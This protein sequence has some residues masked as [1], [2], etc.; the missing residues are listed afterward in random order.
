VPSP[1]TVTR[2]ITGL[3]PNTTHYARAFASNAQGDDWATTTISFTTPPALPSVA[4]NQPAGIDA[5]S[6]DLGATVTDSGGDPPTLTIYYGT[7]DGGTSPAAWQFS[8]SL[9]IQS[10]AANTSIT[11]LAHST[12][13]FYRASASNSAGT[14]WAPSS[15]NFS[16]ATLTLPSVE[17]LAATSI[18]GIST[19]L[20]GR[21][22]STGGDAPTVTFYYGTTDGG[23]D[24]DTWDD[25]VQL[26]TGSG[27]FSRTIGSLSPLTSYFFRAFAENAAG[28][29]WASPSLQFTTTEFVPA[30]IVINEIHYDEDIKSVQG[31]FIELYNNSDDAV[32]LSAWYFSSG[33]D[34]TFPDP[35][36]IP[37]RSYLV[38]AQNPATVQTQFGYSDALG[39]WR[40]KL[41]NDGETI[42]LRD[43]SG[44][45]VDK[46]DYSLGFPW[47]TVGTA[48]SPSI[49]LVNPSLEN[50]IGGHWRAAGNIPASSS[51][52]GVTPAVYIPR[53]SSAWKYT[54]G[55]SI[56]PV[57]G[58]GKNWNQ[59]G[60]DDSSWTTARTP[61]GYSD[62]DD[63]TTIAMEDNFIT[64]FARH[65]FDIAPGQVPSSLDLELLYDDA[66]AVWV[67]GTKVQVT[68]NALAGNIPTPP[69]NNLVA[70]HE[71]NQ[72]EP[73]GYEFFPLAG[74]SG[75]LVEG[76]NSI[77]IQHVN[78]TLS[79]SD[80]SMEASLATGGA[81]PGGYSPRDPS[82]GAA[83]SVL[84]S[85]VAPALRKVE[86]SP[87]QPTS[88][89]P[90]SIT[91][92]A[93]DNDG[94]ASV[95]LDYQ[96]VDPG[97]YINI[98][99]PRYPTNW[100]TLTMADDGTGGDALTGD[101]VFTATLPAS[102]QNHRRLIR[103]RI[104]ATDSLGN[105]VTAPHLD[106]LQPKFAYFVYAAI[107][108]WTASSSSPTYDFTQLE[109]V[110]VYQLIT[111]RQHHE[112]S[113]SI[114]NSTVGGYGGSDYRWQGTLVYDGQVYDHIR[115]RARG[116]VWRYSMGKNMWKFDFNR[117]HRLQA[118][119]DYGK[120]YSTKWRKLNFSSLIQQGNFRQR[121]EQGLFE[122]AGFKL[123]NL[124]GNPA[125]NTNFAHFRI[126]EHADQNGPTSSQY[127]TDFQGLYLA[128]EQLDGQFLD[129]HDLPDGNFYKMEGGSGELNN[130]GAGQP[131]NKADLNAFLTYKQNNK[132]AQWWR[133]NLVLDDYYSFRAVATAIHDYDIHASKNY[134]FYHRPVDPLDPHSDKWQAINWD[135]DL[136]WTTTY[137][138]G[139]IRGPLSEFV[140]SI[141]E[142][143]TGYRNRMR[144]F[145]DLAFNAD[146]TGK[147]LEECA[148]IIHTPGEISFVDADRDMWDR[149]PI[150]VSPYI[151]SSKAGHNKYWEAAAQRNFASMVQHVKNY[152][153]SQSNFIKGNASNL[154]NEAATIPAKPTVTYTGPAGFPSDS[155][156]FQST[157]YADP[158]GA[159]T[160][161]AMQWRIGEIYNDG[162][163]GYVAGDPFVY[164][165][166]PYYA[167][168]L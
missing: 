162:T 122:W 7:V 88:T 75:Y 42:T 112:Q 57:D 161:A 50:D 99:D 58:T 85:N 2:P 69:T 6:A 67:N 166:E 137:G 164:E 129:E 15:A 134:F 139:G 32:D 108:A 110:P 23:S 94:V 36:S 72:N 71:W 97:D 65:T 76:T 96:L 101:D 46:V 82:P 145:L 11:G 109:P 130:Q 156:T 43:V 59:N 13:Y 63:N 142:L 86:H 165:V 37:P 124:L 8:S 17:N 55:N 62:G 118:R 41:S 68:D 52:G 98:D 54:P 105:A 26:G 111:T 14:T 44:N 83:N 103:Y 35:T 104:T 95:T 77:A 48:P 90:V 163:A 114:P 131:S 29:T 113:Q 70:N 146:Q 116:G 4:N 92:K 51:G 157:A 141:P 125:P 21:I 144:E 135:L 24:P 136:T 61:I 153:T 30:T 87:T 140:L 60:Y 3:V 93:T 53:A 5:V 147:I 45:I 47:P 150:L 152:I 25:L 39:P 10:A 106:D 149:N 66:L 9:G 34:F 78:T 20:N 74:A 168:D 80:A 73:D 19:K 64:F 128:I 81:T 28:G 143:A 123:H 121:G 56:P 127:D 84:A 27:N 117:G 148:R 79:S 22:T 91:V 132:D 159:G 107:P 31:E 49:E 18:A 120:K 33:I 151:N 126:I 167:S 160:F 38:V 158:Q 138:G 16:T 12:T 154:Q 40:G 100:T 155:L 1:Q 102:L 133:D 115:F 119:D 89:N